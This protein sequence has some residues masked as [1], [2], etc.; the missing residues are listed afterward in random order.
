M[1]EEINYYG[2]KDEEYQKLKLKSCYT[3]SQ[4]SAQKSKGN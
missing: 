2:N 1:S 3:K 4:E